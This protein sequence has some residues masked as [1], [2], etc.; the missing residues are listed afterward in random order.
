MA[1]VKRGVTARRR[2]KRLLQLTEGQW[3]TR[4]RLIK[5]GREAALRTLSAAYRGRRLRKRDMRALWI[6]RI[7]AAARQN[8][9]SY[10][11][12]ISGL[13]RVGVTLDRKQL[14]EL[15]VRDAAVFTQYAELAKGAPT[16]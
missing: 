2:H 9:L 8:G 10:S 13:K 15:A 11:Q 12:L 5:R 3:G 1:R 7:N 14:A 6:S 16:A 4:R